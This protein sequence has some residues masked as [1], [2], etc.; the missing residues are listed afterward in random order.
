MRNSLNTLKV[1]LLLQL[2]SVATCFLPSSRAFLFKRQQ[3]PLRGLAPQQLGEFQPLQYDSKDKRRVLVQDFLSQ[4]PIPFESMWQQQLT[5][6][7]QHTHRLGLGT[8]NRSSFLTDTETQTV[9]H[10][11]SDV[12][13]SLVHGGVDRILLLQHSPVYTLGTGSD[14]A[15]LLNTHNNNNQHNNNN[16]PIPV[17]RMDRGGE[18]TYHGP[19]QLVI[20]PILDLRNYRQDIHWYMRALEQAIVVALQKSLHMKH[21]TIDDT[22]T[23]VW[24]QNHKVAALGIK[25]RKWITM[26]G[27]AINV[28]P[29]SLHGFEGIVP[30]GLVGR[31]VGCLQQFTEQT[32]TVP[33]VAKAM[34][35][36][37]EEIFQISLVHERMGRT[38]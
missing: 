15:F 30:C 1:L 27:L 24:I 29:E 5:F 31:N 21:A 28:T 2:V 18:V 11:T 6:L 36:A 33:M 9:Q 16:N 37:L 17:V 23:G 13:N 14:P 32:L 35:L 10:E 34:E 20:Y 22:T 25:C 19:G 8:T 7:E 12:S 38:W 4:P 26:H 3:P